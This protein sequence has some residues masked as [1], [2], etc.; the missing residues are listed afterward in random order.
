MERIIRATNGQID[1]DQYK[2][3]SESRLSEL[4][5]AKVAAAANGNGRRRN[6]KG[7]HQTLPKAA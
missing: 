7:K 1:W 6:G 5:Q 4:V 2:D 3:E